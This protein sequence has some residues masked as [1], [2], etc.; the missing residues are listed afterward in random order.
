[1]TKDCTSKAKKMNGAVLPLLLVMIAMGFLSLQSLPVYAD[2]TNL[3]A[4][5]DLYDVHDENVIEVNKASDLSEAI[6][7]A[8]ELQTGTEKAIVHMQSG[9][10]AL[11]KEVRVPENVVLVAEDDTLI[12]PAQKLTYLVRL[13]GSMYGGV[14]DSKSKTDTT[15][16]LFGGNFSND[17]GQIGALQVLRSNNYG[18][19]AKGSKGSKIDGCKVMECKTSGISIL[20]DAK[21]GDTKIESIKGSE[22]VN[23]GTAGINLSWADVGTIEDCVINGNKDKAVSTNSDSSKGCH[24]EAIIGCTIKN[25][26]TNGVHIKP[27]CTLDRFVDNTL[28]GNKDGLT[29]AA[30]TKEKT[31]GASVVREVS[32]NTF[33]S[34]KDAQIEAIGKGALIII[35]D[36]NT[37]ISGKTYGL[38]SMESGKINVSGSNNIFNKNYKGIG[39]QSK[40]S[41][42]VTGQG[43]LIQKNKAYGV[44]AIKKG[45]ITITG[46]KTKISG[47]KKSAIYC[48]TKAKVTYKKKN[49]KISG[50]V[51]KTSKGKIVKK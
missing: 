37:V 31:K 6:D 16:R 49:V 10:Y 29:A 41:I 20:K 39:A 1:M 8:S 44:H 3:D 5:K 22:I 45:T 2:T 18:I 47:N 7:R 38:L 12:S 42:S 19:V 46:K 51:Y 26:K 28:I 27:N 25:N 11:D 33:K 14:Y 21:A 34:T 50:K 9:K 23:N 24:I 36:N 43:N 48:A 35:G 15:I 4:A 40:G 17:N 30:V 32:G 13:S